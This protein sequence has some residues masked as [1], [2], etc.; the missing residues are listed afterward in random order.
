MQLLLTVINISLLI[1]AFSKAF[2]F[3][4]N[5]INKKHVL[6]LKGFHISILISTGFY[7]EIWLYVSLWKNDPTSYLIDYHSKWFLNEFIV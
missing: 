7:K 2:D 5:N 6:A 4:V 1:K 3:V